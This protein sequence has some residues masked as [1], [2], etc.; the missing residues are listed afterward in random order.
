MNGFSGAMC[1]YKSHEAQRNMYTADNVR[2]YREFIQL[3]GKY[4]PGE[5]NDSLAGIKDIYMKL[6]RS[7]YPHRDELVDAIEELVKK[8][9]ENF[10]DFFFQKSIQF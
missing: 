7:Q 8:V 4:F 10:N 1:D 3:T 6:S 2:I 5:P 9:N